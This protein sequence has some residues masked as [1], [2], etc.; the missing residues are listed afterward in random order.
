MQTNDPP[1]PASALPPTY[2]R[3]TIAL[4]GMALVLHLNHWLWDHDGIVLGLP[5]N[6]LYHVL[7]TLLL[8]AG[9]LLLVRTVWPSF[10][11][12]EDAE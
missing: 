7:L 1:P 11:D 10:L 6:L 9:M 5:V 12:D 8:S 3:W 2:P 4:I